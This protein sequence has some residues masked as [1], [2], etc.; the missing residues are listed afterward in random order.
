MKK[1]LFIGVVLILVAAFAAS[2][3]YLGAYFTDSAKSQMADDDRADKV[4]QLRQEYNETQDTQ[5]TAS[6]QT[7]PDSDPT[8]T[9]F[10]PYG[11]PGVSGFVDEY[12]TPDVIDEPENVPERPVLESGSDFLPWYQ[13][14]HSENPDMVGWLQIE[15]SKINYPVM[16]TSVD[17]ANYYLYR[18]FD[19]NES[20]RGCIYAWEGCDV[21]EP[22]DNITLFGHNMKDGSMFAYL[23]TYYNQS[24]WEENPL[25]FFDT[26]TES[27]V[28]KIFA[29]FKTSGTDD[30]GFAY[31]KMVDAENEEAFNEF[32]ATCKELAFYD[33]GITPVYG[34]KLLCLSTCEYTIDN[35]RFVVAAVR[36]T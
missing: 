21:F 23:G 17:N 5:S 30:V 9:S 34:D 31:H 8:E 26:L 36:I 1:G 4:S 11:T 27:H 3:I 32:V 28:Y 12:Y 24:A 19:K 20:I 35:G 16:Q 15:N 22:S 13:E 18:D 10:N 2:A 29:V 25:I 6:S 33:T 7:V 14:L